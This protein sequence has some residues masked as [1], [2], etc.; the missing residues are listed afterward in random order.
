MSRL[1]TDDKT[2]LS[3]DGLI[4]AALIGRVDL[5]IAD[6]EQTKVSRSLPDWFFQ[7]FPTTRSFLL[8]P[9]FIA[10][11]LHGFL[12]ADRSCTDPDGLQDEELSTLLAIRDRLTR[13]LAEFSDTLVQT[14]T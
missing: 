6:C 5:H 13:L 12:F 8:L 4:L 11:D 2:T 1:E 7:H 9:V 14:E 3:C 10:D